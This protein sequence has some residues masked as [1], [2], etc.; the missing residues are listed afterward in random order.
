MDL[1][2]GTASLVDGGLCN[3]SMTDEARVCELLQTRGTG[4]DG[5]KNVFG[6]FGRCRGVSVFRSP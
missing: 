3:E 2:A 6:A 4:H 5:V 1:G